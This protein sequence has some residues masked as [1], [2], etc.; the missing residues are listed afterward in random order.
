MPTTEFYHLPSE[1]R[2]EF[3]VADDGRILAKSWRAVARLSGTTVS[4]ILENLIPKITNFKDSDLET[5]PE[6]LKPLIG[7]KLD[8]NTEI[9]EIIISCIVNY[10]AWESKQCENKTAKRVALTLNAIGTRSYFQRELGWR[11]PKR[12]DIDELKNITSEILNEFKSFK[13]AANR[14]PGIT[15]IVQNTQAAIQNNVLAIVIPKDLNE[16]FS[17]REWVKETHHIELT[18]GECRSIGR[19]VSGNMKTLKLEEG[20]KYGVSKVY[21]YYDIPVL[22]TIW[23]SWLLSKKQNQQQNQQD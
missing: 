4:N 21:S 23:E 12:R 13:N 20:E 9:N 11:S 18:N 16:P 15:H 7:L 8:A 17:I 1:V 14:F 22:Q 5:F 6:S 10:F 3:V 2:N 19:L